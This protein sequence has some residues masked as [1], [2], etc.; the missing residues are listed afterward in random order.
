MRKLFSK[1]NV[2]VL[3]ILLSFK[4]NADDALEGF[5]FNGMIPRRVEGLQKIEVVTARFNTSIGFNK[6]SGLVI[7]CDSILQ[8]SVGGPNG[9]NSYGSICDFLSE[10]EIS[11]VFICAD[12][13]VGHVF[14]ENK[15]I[16]SVEWKVRA[17]GENCVGG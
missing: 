3:L 8:L 12:E 14:I 5:A 9:N 15:F 13:M 6:R 10:N 11:R 16:D 17:I 1:T 4:S 7:R 2:V